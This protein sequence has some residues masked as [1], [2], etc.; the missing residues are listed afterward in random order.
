MGV[1]LLFKSMS[2]LASLKDAWNGDFT[3]SLVLE[4]GSSLL[5]APSSFKLS[6]GMGL[7]GVDWRSRSFLGDGLT[8]LPDLVGVPSGDVVA[9]NAL[10]AAAA[11]STSSSTCMILR[12]APRL[13]GPPDSLAD[14]RFLTLLVLSSFP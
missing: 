14:L 9:L 13:E 6:W 3:S 4:E 5:L 1:V 11:T 7:G 2:K 12:L 10:S 8:K